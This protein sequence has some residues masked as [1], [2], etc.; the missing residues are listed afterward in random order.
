M[1]KSLA[2]AFKGIFKDTI[3]EKIWVNNDKVFY[4]KYAQVLIELYSTQKENKST[5][6]EGWV[7]TMKG[8][9]VEIFSL[10]ISRGRISMY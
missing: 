10:Q 8:K 6:V 4:N 5:V 2:T 1:G 3:P 9:N 7:R